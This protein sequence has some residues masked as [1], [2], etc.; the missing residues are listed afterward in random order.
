MAELNMTDKLIEVKKCLIYWK[1]HTINQL[2]RVAV[3][4]SLI[5]STLVYPQIMLPKLPGKF[6]NEVQEL[7]FEFVWDRKWDK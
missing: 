2:R 7:C 3:L 6:M 4:K 5:L 1:K